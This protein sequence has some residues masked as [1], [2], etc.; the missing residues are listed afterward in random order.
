MR[1][2]ILS[3]VLL[4]FS[5][6]YSK[7]LIVSTI[8]PL[9]DIAKAVGKDKIVA[10]YIIPPSAPVHF[11]EYKISDIKNVIS[12]DIFIYIGSGEPNINNLIKHVKPEKRLLVS[13]LPQLVKITTFEFEGE[14]KHHEEDHNHEGSIHPAVWLDPYNAKVIAK[15]VYEKLSKIDPSNNDFY[16]KNLDQFSSECDQLIKFGTS[17]FSKLKNKNFISYH[18]T[19]PYFVKRFGLVYL[20]VIELGH[21]R[22]PTPKHIM[23]IIRKIKKFKIKSIFASKQFYNPRYGRLIKNAT[24]INIVFLDPFGIDKKYIPMMN[25]LINDIYTGLK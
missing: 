5:F 25:Q 14:E 9:S 3:L 24:N 11:Y 21:G 10:K 13:G 16:K 23:E 18:Y 22:E 1:I 19:F 4:I 20:D 8:K 17:K 15:A 12:A 7:P 2:L 6:G